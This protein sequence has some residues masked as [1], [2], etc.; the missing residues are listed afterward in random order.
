MERK[1][2]LQGKAVLGSV[3]PQKPVLGTIHREPLQTTKNHG[4]VKRV[5]ESAVAPAWGSLKKTKAPQQEKPTVKREQTPA[6]SILGEEGKNLIKQSALQNE[7]QDLTH[8]KA[9][10]ETWQDTSMADWDPA[11]FRIFVGDLGPDATDTMLQQAF[12]RYKSLKK[13]RIV[14]DRR[15]NKSKGYGFVALSSPDDFLSAMKEMQNQFIGSRPIKLRK[16]TWDERAAGEKERKK[17]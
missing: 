8:R 17:T 3:P 2:V 7:K 14:R 11:D 4:A 9:A 10:G 16:S 12:S 13:V 1:P 5:A 6:F 15:S